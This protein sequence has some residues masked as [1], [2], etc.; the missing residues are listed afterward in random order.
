MEFALKRS[1]VRED[2]ITALCGH[3]PRTVERGAR[4]LTLDKG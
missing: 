1:I 2:K 4:D 3:A